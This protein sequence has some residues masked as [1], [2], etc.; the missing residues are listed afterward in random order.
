MWANEYVGCRRS[1]FGTT[2]ENSGKSGI[3]VVW[4]DLGT[5]EARKLPYR[6][7]LDDWSFISLATIVADPIAT[8]RRSHK[9]A[10]YLEVALFHLSS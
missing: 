5:R 2:Q 10:K 4:G 9:A 3:G 1:T 7:D 6:S 8:I